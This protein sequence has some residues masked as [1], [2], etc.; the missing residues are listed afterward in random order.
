MRIRTSQSGFTLMEIVI[1]TVI[2]ALVVA[3]MMSVFIAAKRFL[4]GT[5]SQTVNAEIGRL[6]IEEFQQNVTA[7]N[8]G[9][10]SNEL[11]NTP[12]S[13]TFGGWSAVYTATHNFPFANITRIEAIISQ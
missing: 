6:F 9:T 7:S 3:G 10:S 11:T 8:W 13:K 5:K 1:A 4:V 2:F 12:S